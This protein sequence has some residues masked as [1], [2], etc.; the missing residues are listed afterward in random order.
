MMFIDNLFFGFVVDF[1]EIVVLLCCV[2]II[3]DRCFDLEYNYKGFIFV[4][5]EEW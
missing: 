1:I 2:K 3:R 5:G 4:Y